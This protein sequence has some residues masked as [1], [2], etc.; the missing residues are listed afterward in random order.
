MN[1]ISFV[2]VT[3][4][5]AAIGGNASAQHRHYHLHHHATPWQQHRQVLVD[6]HGHAVVAHHD[7]YHHVLAPQAQFRGT[8]YTYNDV[9]YFYPTQ[10]V[11]T[12]QIAAA[13]PQPVAVE[14]GSF[15][16]VDDLAGR[17]EDI[18]NQFCLDLHYNYQHNPGFAE[19]YAEA[20]QILQA[21]QW[22]HAAEHQQDREGLARTLGPMDDLFHHVQ[23]DVRGWQRIHR[24]QIGQLGI[25]DKMVQME[26]LIHHLCHDV[27]V[28]PSHDESHEQAP[29]PGGRLEQAPPPGTPLRSPPP[30]NI[31]FTPI[32]SSRPL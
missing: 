22:A 11:V 4:S 27:G 32:P 18:A 6:P 25:V 2:A 28:R 10:P 24:R 31:P 23:E 16:H 9:H 30:A 8:Y 26:S 7:H 29:P 19:T 12:A 17:L 5:L 1:R 21:A 20:F 3:V 14:F 15:S 13:P